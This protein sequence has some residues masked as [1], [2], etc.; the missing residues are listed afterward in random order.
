MQPARY[1]A[2]LAAATVML[3]ALALPC[4]RAAQAQQLSVSNMS[5]LDFGRFVAGS[6]GTVVLSAAGVRSRTG[7]V[8]LLTSPAT[9]PAR[10]NIGKSGNGAGGKAVI[11]SLPSNGSVR[12]SSG[13]HSMAVNSFVNNPQSIASV[14]NGGVALGVGATLVVAPNQP[15]GNYTGSFPLTVNYQ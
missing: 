3:A 4:Q 1:P 7:G 2:V 8:I 12:L 6:G 13:A 11:I 5:N 10:F 15:P 9:G 14:P